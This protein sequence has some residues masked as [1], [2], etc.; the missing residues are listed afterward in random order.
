MDEGPWYSRASAALPIE[1]RKACGN[2]FT[3]STIYLFEF[4]RFGSCL[5]SFRSPLRPSAWEMGEFTEE[6][7][8]GRKTH[9]TENCYNF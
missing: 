4:V 2:Q 1:F 5:R 9:T 7:T 3:V 8:H 6:I